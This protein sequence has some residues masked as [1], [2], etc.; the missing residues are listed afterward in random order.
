MSARTLLVLLAAAA[1]FN[2]CTAVGPV[3]EYMK[4]TKDLTTAANVLQ[5]LYPK[6]IS[7]KAKFTLLAPTNDVSPRW[8]AG[9]ARSIG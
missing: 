4:S 2:V 7:E 6:P 8:T 3:I 9:H 5:Q 1:V